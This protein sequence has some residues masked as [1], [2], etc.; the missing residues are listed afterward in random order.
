MRNKLKNVDGLRQSY[1][2]VFERYGQKRRYKPKKVNGEWVDFDTTVLLKDITDLNGRPIC[3]H[4]WF[5]FTKGF[6]SLKLIEIDS[7]VSIQF[8]ARSKQYVKGYVNHREW[9]DERE[10]D[11]KLSHPTKFKILLGY[12][13]E[14]LICQ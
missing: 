1:V 12:T 7:G 3:D 5:N 13:P 8:D 4:L 10:V 14:S 6:E 9:I 2:G 11:Y